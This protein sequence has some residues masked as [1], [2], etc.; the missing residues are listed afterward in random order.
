MMSCVSKLLLSVSQTDKKKFDHV[1][2]E[3]WLQI[4][5]SASVLVNSIWKIALRCLE[6]VWRR[7]SGKLEDQLFDSSAWRSSKIRIAI[8]QK[9]M[10]SMPSTFSAGLYIKSVQICDKSTDPWSLILVGLRSPEAG[11]VRLRERPL[12]VIVF[13][14]LKS[15]KHGSE[16]CGHRALVFRNHLHLDNISDHL[17][18]TWIGS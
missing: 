15:G 2:L 7:S 14:Y 9:P 10:V 12:I 6:E 4:F 1:Q 17:L 8:N 5:S 16:V 18:W 3:E 13:K 11:A